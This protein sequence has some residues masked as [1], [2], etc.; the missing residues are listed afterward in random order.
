MDSTNENKMYN[1]TLDTLNTV[2]KLPIVRVNREEFLKNQFSSSPY[3]EQIIQ[4]GPQSVFTVETLRNK[5]KKVI[6]S[7]TNK[8]SLTSFA[9]GLPSNI[10]V[11]L[12]AGG[13]DV[14]QYFGFAIN[15]AQKI[16]YLFGEDDLFSEKNKLSEEATVKVIGYLG[17]MF[18]VS[19]ATSII[20]K[21]STIA[22]KNIGKKVAAQAL[23]KT[24][25]YPIVKR[26]GAI[27]GQKI[28]KKTVEKTITK[29]VPVIGGIVSGGITYLTFKP[30]G[31]RLAN[32]LANN[33]EGVY[34][35][36][37]ELNPDFIN[38][39]NSHIDK[40]EIEVIDGDFVDLDSVE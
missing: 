19:G 12:A 8:T 10:A 24:T 16:A 27:I 22:G 36:D 26:V 39:L 2:A 29:A 14:A 20:A 1:Y 18:G 7:S 21:T 15:M 38:E 40:S 23:T 30:L 34:D 35:E 17:V 25:W 6:K 28:T 11:M 32:V 37:L 5:A 13:A 4:N 3:I 31:N 9:S 33:L